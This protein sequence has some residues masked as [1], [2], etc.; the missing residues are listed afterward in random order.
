MRIEQFLAVFNAQYRGQYELSQV[1]G[2][3]EYVVTQA[4]APAG[5]VVTRIGVRPDGNLP[6]SQIEKIFHAMD[7]PEN[8]PFVGSIPIPSEEL[9]ETFRLAGLFLETKDDGKTREW[10]LYTRAGEPVNNVVLAADAE[11]PDVDLAGQNIAR[12][13]AVELASRGVM[14]TR[15]IDSAELDGLANELHED[16]KSKLPAAVKLADDIRLHYWRLTQPQRVPAGNVERALDYVQRTSAT[17]PGKVSVAKLPLAHPGPNSANVWGR[18]LVFVGD[19][20]PR[21]IPIIIENGSHVVDFKGTKAALDAIEESVGK[22]PAGDF[23]KAIFNFEGGEP[24]LKRFEELEGSG[25]DDTDRD[26]R[27]GR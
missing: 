8:F 10:D 12:G 23:K 7:S 21:S 14:E 2:G 13:K 19:G 22:G 3:N 6:A 26:R 20:S 18:M 24:A 16:L 9:T 4:G 25:K 27:E 1:E 11:E 5:S 15:E 17:T